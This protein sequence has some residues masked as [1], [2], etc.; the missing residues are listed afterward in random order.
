MIPENKDCCKEEPLQIHQNS[1]NNLPKVLDLNVTLWQFLLELLNDPQHASHLIS[2]TS[3]DGEF[4]LHDSEEVARMWGMRKNKTNMNYDQLSRALRYYYDKNIIKK[5]N[6]QKFVYKFVCLPEISKEAKVPF[7]IRME[8]L[9]MR[10]QQHSRQ[11]SI[12]TSH[13]PMTSPPSMVVSHVAKTTAPTTISPRNSLLSSKKGFE[14]NHRRSPKNPQMRNYRRTMKNKPIGELEALKGDS[15]FATKSLLQSAAYLRVYNQMQMLRQNGGLPSQN[16]G[17]PQQNGGG[18]SCSSPTNFNLNKDFMENFSKSQD[19]MENFSK[20]QD[21]ATFQQQKIGEILKNFTLQGGMNGFN[22]P[23]NQQQASGFSANQQQASSFSANQQPSNFQQ[24]QSAQQ[25]TTVMQ[26][27]LQNMYQH[28][29]HYGQQLNCRQQLSHQE[30]N[31]HQ[32]S[33]N[34]TNNNNNLTN[35]ELIRENHLKLQRA[36]QQG[37]PLNRRNERKRKGAGELQ[38][39]HKKT[40]PNSLLIPDVQT[41]SVDLM[42]RS[43]LLKKSLEL[44][45]DGTTSQSSLVPMIHHRKSASFPSFAAEDLQEKGEKSPEKISGQSGSSS[46]DENEARARPR[47]TQDF[48]LDR[49]K[50]FPDLQNFPNMKLPTIKIEPAVSSDEAK[51]EENTCEKDDAQIVKNV[52]KEEDK[53]K[54]TC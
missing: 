33:S 3:N 2:W 42:R 11:Q 54:K 39:G 14:Q 7:K 53:A 30:L 47:E 25:Y 48:S 28:S 26:R 44:A 36:L 32:E 18:S 8:R 52:E 37:N 21:L 15:P 49:S 24:W 22:F 51:E 45:E 17:I 29:S 9:A 50:S 27:A 23:T 35:L 10:N 1:N 19:F 34:I 38:R 5:V 40:A 4:K 31:C 12:I 6:G 16:G 13:Q 43:S 20:S 46:N 41:G